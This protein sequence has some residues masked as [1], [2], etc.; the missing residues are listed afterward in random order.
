MKIENFIDNLPRVLND[1]GGFAERP[2]KEVISNTKAFLSSIPTY[3]QKI[4]DPEN[5]ITA[6]GHGTITID[7][8]YR[9]NFISVEIGNTQIGWFSEMPDG[10]NPSSTELISEEATKKIIS[11]LDF[12]YGRVI[13]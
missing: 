3:Y 4:L 12:I 8:Y 11:Y 13:K 7:F 9:K 5:C 2:S 1:D 6:T 10:T